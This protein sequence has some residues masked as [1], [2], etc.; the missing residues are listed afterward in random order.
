MKVVQNKWM[1]K[2]CNVD[3]VTIG[4]ELSRSCTHDIFT[5]FKTHPHNP[6]HHLHHWTPGPLSPLGP[7]HLTGEGWAVAGILG[8]YTPTDW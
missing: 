3:A 5:G 1:E 6:P 7:Y 4:T 8:L 2:D